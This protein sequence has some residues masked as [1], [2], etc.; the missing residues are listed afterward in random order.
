MKLQKSMYLL[1]RINYKFIQREGEC[2]NE[3]D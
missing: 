3:M 2:L 1:I